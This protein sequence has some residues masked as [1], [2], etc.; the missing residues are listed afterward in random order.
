MRQFGRRGNG[1]QSRPDRPEP[2][3]A[4]DT[5]AGMARDDPTDR[6]KDGDHIARNRAVWNGYAESYLEAGR[7]AWAEAEPTWG[8]WHIPDSELHV[9]PDDLAGKDVVELGCGTGY[10][11]A[12]LARRGGHPVGVDLTERQLQSASAFQ[13]EFGVHFPLVQANAEMVPLR[14]ASFDL[15]ISE[16]GAS[17]WCD[18]YRWIPEAAR[19]LRPG[20]ELTY[21]VNGTLFVLCEPDLIAEG[22]ATETLRRDYFGM[23]RFEWPDEDAVDFHL[24]YGDMI[25]LLRRTGFEVIDLLELRPPE[26]AS[27]TF[28]LVS[29]EW[30]RRWPSEEI[31]K[32]RKL[33]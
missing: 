3:P 11:S 22:A 24:G 19:L 23:R 16:Y 30:A 17:I 13:E 27:T 20:G 9:L 1:G 28:S 32:V 8:V 21:L 18:P 2:E 33:G 7:R 6:V 10:I 4:L 15:A 29:L 14:D 26:G 25:R 31:W 5:I 12:W